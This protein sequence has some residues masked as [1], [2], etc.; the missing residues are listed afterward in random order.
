MTLK[1][2]SIRRIEDVTLN[3][4]TTTKEELILISSNWAEK[5]IILFKK[6]LSQGGTCRIG[7]DVLKVHKTDVIRPISDKNI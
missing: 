7:G 3:G 2:Q 5:E 1:K 6:V 4:K